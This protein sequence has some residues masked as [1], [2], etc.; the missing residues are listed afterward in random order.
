MEGVTRDFSG[1]EL[2]VTSVR[3]HLQFLEDAN[4]LHISAKAPE[5]SCDSWGGVR[6]F[7]QTVQAFQ[8]LGARSMGL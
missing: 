5:V 1:G 7:V 3:G 8:G 4:L 2:L 6:G